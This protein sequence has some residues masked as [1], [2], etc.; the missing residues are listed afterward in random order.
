MIAVINPIEQFKKAQDSKRKSDLAQIQ[1][2][3][4]VYY[5]DYHRYP[6][7]VESKISKDGTTNGIVNWG[8]DFRPYMDVLPIDPSSS[9]SYAYWTDIT[10]QSYALY[11]A[12]DRGSKDPQACN[13]GSA[14]T[15]AAANS[16]VCGGTNVACT[17]G[18]TSSNIAP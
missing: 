7:T 16:L 9:K 8:E 11:T 14:C 18:V 13:G 17:Y 1:R 3:L 5:Q 10:G 2:A 4:E 12:L 15:N 6:Y